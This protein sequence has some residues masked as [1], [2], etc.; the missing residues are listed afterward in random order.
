MGFASIARTLAAAALAAL[1]P[2]AANA[3]DDTQGIS[4]DTITIGELGPASGSASVFMPLNYGAIAYLRY[5]NDQGGVHGRKFKIEMVDSACNEATGI[6][7]AKKLIFSDKVFMIMSQPCSGVA[8]A[9]KP[10]LLEQKIPWM[11]VSANPHISSPPVPG[12]FHTAYTGQASGEAMA[13]F[14]MSKPGVTKIALVQH[15]NDWAHGYCDPAVDYI[16]SHGGSVVATTALERGATDSTAQVLQIKA[17]GAQA[18]M[19]CVYQPELVVFLRDMQK[20]AVDAL[21]LAALGADF[22]QVLTAIPDHSY[23]K[24]HFFQP[25]QFKAKLN[26]KPLQKYRDIFVKY[27]TKSELPKDGVPTNFY[28]FGVPAAIVA[29]K[30]FEIAGPEP[31]RESWEKAVESLKDFDTGVLADTENFGPDKHF[32]VSKMYAVGLSPEAKET[33]YKSWGDAL[34]DEQ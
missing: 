1:L 18:V 20:F 25:Y 30:A 14:A 9:I 12:I 29:V 24:Q 23:L 32:G 22:D 3:A 28:Y 15:S 17:A 16:K 33:V 10:M 7:A 5:I 21:T 27:L 11:G 13:S 31:T 8:M 6:A 26:T 34:P 4:K 19:A 2:L